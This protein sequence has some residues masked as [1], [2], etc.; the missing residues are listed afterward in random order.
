MSDVLVSS[1]ELT[2][3]MVFSLCE[4]SYSLVFLKTDFKK[5]SYGLE[6]IWSSSLLKK[7]HQIYTSLTT[8]AAVKILPISIGYTGGNTQK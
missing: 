1:S 6:T 5:L 8:K 4:N 7:Y 2:H 3:I